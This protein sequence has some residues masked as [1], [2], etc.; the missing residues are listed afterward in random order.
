MFYSRLNQVFGNVWI[1][2]WVNLHCNW[3]SV[4]SVLNFPKQWVENT[5]ECL[6]HAKMIIVF[7]P[8]LEFPPYSEPIQGSR[9]FKLTKRLTKVKNHTHVKKVGHTSEFLFDIYWST[10]KTNNYLKN[11]WSRPIKNKII[12]NFK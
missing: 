10:W 6:I 8:H 1:S 4:I 2:K 12:L 11:C 7:T 5:Q 9:T 3:I